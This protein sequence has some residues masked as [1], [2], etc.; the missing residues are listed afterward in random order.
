MTG[1]ERAS[2][3]LIYNI[4]YS[5]KVHSS[6]KPITN[7]TFVVETYDEDNQLRKKRYFAV[8]EIS[9]ERLD[10]YL[11]EGNRYNV[12]NSAPIIKHGTVMMTEERPAEKLDIHALDSSYVTGVGSGYRFTIKEYGSDTVHIEDEEHRHLYKYKIVSK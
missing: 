6:Q 12:K 5:W 7:K 3:A 2:L 1:F 11:D 4:Y 10:I 9:T 8:R